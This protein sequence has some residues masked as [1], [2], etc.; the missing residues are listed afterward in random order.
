MAHAA[1]HAAADMRTLPLADVAGGA[2][3][4]VDV[5]S[6]VMALTLLVFSGGL[7]AGFDLALSL[8]LLAVALST[9]ILIWRG[10]ISIASST[11]QDVPI[12]VLVVPVAG[13]AGAMA[14]P[15]PVRVLHALAIMGLTSL[16][17]GAALWTLGRFGAARLVRFLPFPV[18]AGFLAGTGFLML[19]TALERGAGLSFSLGLSDMGAL[20]HEVDL[21]AALCI[22]LALAIL[23]LQRL[24]LGALSPLLLALT[25]LLFYWMAGRN[26]MDGAQLRAMGWLPDLASSGTATGAALAPPET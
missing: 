6:R 23:A 24:R 15:E 20:W 13:L 3:V 26:G 21:A 18:M 22:A 8:M 25:V 1:L 10:A 14:A 17:M 7:A 19:R 11:L 2:F 9:A 4:A 5:A 12:A 16:L